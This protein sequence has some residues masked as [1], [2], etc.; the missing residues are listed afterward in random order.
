MPRRIFITGVGAI[1]GLGIGVAALWEGL[2]AGRSAIGPIRRF[3]PSGFPWRLGAEV[4]DFSAKDF[5]PKSY[6]KAVKVMV[7][8][9]ELA[10]A[11]A[12]L[13]A[14]DA[15]LVTKAQ[16]GENASGGPSLTYA[17]ERVGCHIGAGLICSDTQEISAAMV[18]AREGSPSPD[19][20]ARTNGLTLKAWGSVKPHGGGG[21]ENLQPLWMLKYLP[22]MLACHVTII[23]GTEGP[24]NTV[25]CAE[26]S[27]L[28]CIGESCRVIERGA[29]DVCFS[30][31]AESKLNLMGVVRQGLTGRLA[32][33]GDAKDHSVLRP[34]DPQ[35]RGTVPGEAGGLLILE[36]A[37]SGRWRRA[38]GDAG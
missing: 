14:D 21:M 7:R 13:A 16:Q 3:D 31:G 15:G 32:E 1:T 6:R 37:E 30:G 20:L 27:A 35:A 26:A 2:C 23:H 10:V 19:Q 12:K 25:T 28:L 34:Y 29:A 5:V 36:E 11:A 17:P 22:N 8:D 18:T 38:E 9:T 24:S 4:Q 33:T